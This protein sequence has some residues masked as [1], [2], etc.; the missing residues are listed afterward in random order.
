MSESGAE[1]GENGILERRFGRFGRTALLAIVWLWG[2]PRAAEAQLTSETAPANAPRAADL[3]PVPKRVQVDVPNLADSATSPGDA[4]PEGVTGESPANDSVRAKV[5]P[6]RAIEVEVDYP[7]EAEGEALVVLQF[8]VTTGGQ[9][10]DPQV[11]QG[12]EPF[13]SA[14]VQATSGWRFEPARVGERIV[15]AKI[16]FEVRFE[17]QPEPAVIEPTA[18]NPSDQPAARRERAGIA[19]ATIQATV[20]A[21]VA[22][23]RP[24]ATVSLSRAEARQVPG[25]FGDPFRAV[26]VM[27]GVSPLVS[28]LPVFYVRG[29]PPGNIGNFIGGVKVPLLYHAFI[30]ASV[31]HPMLIDRISLHQGPYPAEY[32]RFAGAVIAADLRR[33]DRDLGYGFSF[34]LFDTGAYG[35]TPFAGDR[36]SVFV[37]G[38][39]SHAGLL[40]SALS[41]NEL[42]FWNYQ[43]LADYELSDKDVLS[44]FAFGAFDSLQDEDDVAAREFHRIDL[45]WDRNFSFDTS[46]RLAVTLGADRSD[47]LGAEVLSRSINARYRLN[48][49]TS[50]SGVLGVGGSVEYGAFELDQDSRSA[51]F[52][53]IRE[54][55]VG[56]D[57]LAAGG[58]VEYAWTPQPSVTVSPSLRA[59]IYNSGG[60]TE[61]GIEPRVTARYRVT[62]QVNIVHGVGVAHQPPNYVTQV[63]GARVAGLDGGLQTAVHTTS[64]VEA[65]LPYA[66]RGNLSLFHNAV[67]AVTDPFSATQDFKLRPEEV[68]RRPLARTYGLELTLNRALTRRFGGLLSYTL[69]RSTRTHDTYVTLSGADRTHVLN[70]AGLYTLGANWRLGAR[71]VFYSGVPGRR[72]GDR[73]IFDQS[74]ADPFFRIDLQLE[75]RFR[76]GDAGYWSIVAE[77]L[78][79]TGSTE[80]L[81]RLC[82]PTG[83]EDTQV[84]PIFLP[85]LRV[86]GHF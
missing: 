76:V 10:T 74:R 15:A 53:E 30:F 71:S 5:S 50:E 60:E 62:E 33:P 82:D 66:L 73:R 69:S 63:P 80:T 8:V 46:Q 64:G 36:G 12:D 86:E 81:R 9:V 72:T 40:A 58:F 45:R 56:Q 78:N 29:A 61:V 65:Q 18:Q 19:E 4:A 25:A 35:H 55:F 3:Q 43:A 75:R 84:G 47:G 26:G 57:D 20:E 42:E 41:P 51:D 83:C 37:A 22:G 6:P 68:R 77:I 21:V 16:Q 38:R 44:V 31:I 23:E 59:D 70:L 67:F 27:P 13:A 39:Y 79:A 14:A 52:E 54:L 17:A 24:P 85:N 1:A 11:I 2:W 48:H 32:G 28:G 34:G 7:S 49:R